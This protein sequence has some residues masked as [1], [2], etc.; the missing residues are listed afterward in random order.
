M[1]DP[2]RITIEEH[3]SSQNAKRVILSEKNIDVHTGSVKT[4][5]YAHSEIH[6][7][8]HFFYQDAQELGTGVSQNYLITTPNNTKW[9]HIIFSL[10]G[11]GVTEFL[12]Y[13]ASDRNGTTLENIYNNNRNSIKTSGLTIHKGTTGG[14]TDGTLLLKE[15]KGGSS[16]G[17]S[18]TSAISREDDEL[19]L[20]QNTKYL[21]KVTSSS[22]TNLTNVKMSW[23]EEDFNS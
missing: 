7:G 23:Y 20:K 13:E 16:G 12:L 21:L 15:Y 8:D 5:D 1:K 14:T 9:A 17:V 19:I 11:N 6:S 22:A 3:D 18:R 10:D 4:I 2:T